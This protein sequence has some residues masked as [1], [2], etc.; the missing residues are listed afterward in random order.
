MTELA[1]GGTLGALLDRLTWDA[2]S[3]WRDDAWEIG[4]HLNR[5]SRAAVVERIERT[6]D[7]LTVWCRDA[8]FP[9]HVTSNRLSTKQCIRA[10]RA[11]A[12]QTP[13]PQ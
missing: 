6:P 11:A 1:P 5:V 9:V 7:R 3:P 10:E 2:D 12:G 13:P 4:Q 8:P